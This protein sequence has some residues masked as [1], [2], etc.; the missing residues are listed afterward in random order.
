[1]KQ[2]PSLIHF[3]EGVCEKVGS[4]AEVG[5]LRMYKPRNAEKD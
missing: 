1:M 5:P 3:V 4:V 2:P